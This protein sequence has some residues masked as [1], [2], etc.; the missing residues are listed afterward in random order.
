MNI[1]PTAIIS[2]SA[3]ISSTAQVGPYVV[4]RGHVEIADNVV[5]DQF[6]TIG[7]SNTR[8]K[9]GEGA[10][11]FPGAVVGEAPQDLKYKGE[12]TILE[13][14]KNTMIREYATLHVGTPDGGGIT[15]VGDNCLIMAYVHIA[16][17]CMIGNHVVI[18]NSTQLAGHVEMEDHVKVGGVCAFNQFVR[19]G[20]YSYI[21]GDSSVNK[22]V[23]PFA[24]AQG[25]YAVMR[26]A[27]QVGMDR[28]GFSKNDIEQVR[29]ALRIIIKGGH[30]VEEALERVSKECEGNPAVQSLLQFA[31]K[32][33]RGLAL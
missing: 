14:G 5:I 32:S 4:V 25:S 22:D 18:A 12:P 7:A 26:A 17:D 33:E 19:L 24:I 8:V 23:L 15:K 1:H 27:N 13:V 9:I 3:K 29:R 28:S 30:T 20:K 21:A 10:R 16:H 6:A 2:E 31:R 11:I